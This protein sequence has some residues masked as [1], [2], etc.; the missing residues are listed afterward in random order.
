MILHVKDN[1]V[2]NCID[3]PEG[4]ID[5]F[6]N[7]PEGSMDKRVDSYFTWL[8]VTCSVCTRAGNK[9]LIISYN[10]VS[11]VNSTFIDIIKHNNSH[12][13]ALTKN[14]EI[15]RSISPWG[16][17]WLVYLTLLARRGARQMIYEWAGP[18]RVS[19]RDSRYC[20]AESVSGVQRTV[21]TWGRWWRVYFS[22][23]AR[24]RRSSD[25]LWA[26]RVCE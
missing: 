1:F 7:S 23:L 14:Y 15:Q 20:W 12:S 3:N 19:G 17:R 5:N 10:T 24:T 8:S 22:L 2:N 25:D 13:R 16:R 11:I 26:C 18:M 4:N 9:P 21:S 6:V